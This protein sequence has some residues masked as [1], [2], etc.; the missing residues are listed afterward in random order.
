VPLIPAQDFKRIGDGDT[1]PNTGGMGSYC[2]LPWAPSGLVEDV[3]AAVVR[4]TLTELA[5]R[6]CGFAGLLYCGL[7]LTADGP[8]VI[9]FNCRFG[10]PEVQSVLALLDTPL[11]PLL[12]AAATGALADTPAVTWKPGAAVT[13]VAASEGY[14]GT[15]RTGDVIT[16]ASRPDGS[17][18]PGILHA[19]TTFADGALVTAGGR[20]LSAT[21]VSAD[22]GTARDAAYALLEQVHWD[23]AQH[24]TDIAKA[25]V[26]GAVRIPR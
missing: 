4:P 2:P 26:D 19:G 8:K 12:Y 23:G 21:A 25:A 7:V 6:D 24:R 5:R 17:A 15:S 11:G 1:G 14:P 18:T 10:D 20:V 9:E 13:V 16:G 3:M 22:L